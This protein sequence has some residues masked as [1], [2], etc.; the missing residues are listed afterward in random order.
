M[1]IAW[2]GLAW[3]AAATL[4]HFGGLFS[5]MALQSVS[6]LDALL[7]PISDEDAK[8]D[9]VQSKTALL[10]LSLLQVFAIAMVAIGGAG[11]LGQAGLHWLFPDAARSTG[12]ELLAVSTGLVPPWWRAAR[13]ARRQDFSPLSVLLHR[14]AFEHPELAW[15]LFKRDLKSRSHVPARSDYLL[16]TGLARSGTTSLL[17]HLSRVERFDSLSYAQLPFL[18][19]PNL[20][21]RIYNPAQGEAVERS[22]KDGLLIHHRSVEALEEYF[23]KV[24]TRDAFI[25]SD[26][27]LP[28]EISPDQHSDYLDYQRL[29]RSSPDQIYLAKNNNA[30]LRYPALR[31]HNPHF[32]AVIL[33]RHPLHHAAS[34]LDKHLQYSALQTKDPFILDMMDWLGHHEFGC[35]HKPMLWD[36]SDGL[37][38]EP[39]LWGDPGALDYWLKVW[40]AYYTEALTVDDQ[41]CTWVCYESF[42]EHPTETVQQLLKPWKLTWPHP[43]IE[44]FQ[45]A[46]E[47]S[48]PIDSDVLAQAEAIH[49]R[50][51]SRSNR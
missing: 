17:N 27:L 28:H 38:A 43:H 10:T 42:C 8:L 48:H 16:V 5:K 25:A 11:L 6:L 12:W 31:R 33:F 47:V 15:R 29:T 24:L 19:S 23:F 13:K 36:T 3:A 45:N 30:L 50:L 7:T 35:G 32:R 37:R 9:A 1:L 26:R 14:I 51:M 2:A 44:S 46:R 21:R 40:T 22:H 4:L 18:L 34:L 49:A 20:W 39:D 41:G